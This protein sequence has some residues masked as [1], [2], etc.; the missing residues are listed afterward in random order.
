MI[1]ELIELTKDE[2]DFITNA[3]NFSALI[4][5]SLSELNWVG[6][7]MISKGNLLLG[8]FQGK[9]ACIHISMGKGVCGTS[10]KMRQTIIVDDV[11]EFPGHIACDS[12]S[13]SEIVIPIIKN[14]KLYGVLDIDSPVKSRFSKL[15][16]ELFEKMLEI[17][18]E[19]SDMEK[20]YEYYN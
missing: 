11:H 4:F 19:N 6:F 18:I 10:A 8:P 16:Q 1:Q 15:E 2:K 17:L 5:N 14:D 9:P 13:N 20:I 7:Y 12:A 3:S